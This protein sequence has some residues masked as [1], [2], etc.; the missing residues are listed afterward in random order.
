MKG[1]EG[2]KEG[3]GGFDNERRAGRG[4]GREQRGVSTTPLSESFA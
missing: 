1:K 2:R 4:G 3:Q